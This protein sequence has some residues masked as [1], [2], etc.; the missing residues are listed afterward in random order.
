[1]RVREGQEWELPSGATSDPLVLRVVE[2]IGDA[3]VVYTVRRSA[4]GVILD[5]STM[6][7]RD[8]RDS[9]VLVRGPGALQAK[10]RRERAEH[11]AALLI[12]AARRTEPKPQR[13]DVRF[14]GTELVQVVAQDEKATPSEA[15]AMLRD[16]LCKLNGYEITNPYDAGEIAYV[17]PVAALQHHGPTRRQASATPS[18]APQSTSERLRGPSD[19]EHQARS[20][21]TA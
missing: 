17:V 11:F 6:W 20:A 7:H 10:Q 19:E 18:T 14:D 16:A 12:Y 3:A 2:I 15:R 21:R 13:A 9:G 8:V 1:M 4:P 5:R